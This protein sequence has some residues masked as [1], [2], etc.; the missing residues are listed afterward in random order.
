MAPHISFSSLSLFLIGL[1]GTPLYIP[2]WLRGDSWGHTFKS[3]LMASCLFSLPVYLSL[4]SSL[5]LVS[6][7]L[8]F[9]CLG[10]IILFNAWD[11]DAT[12]AMD[13]MTVLQCNAGVNCL[14]STTG[15]VYLAR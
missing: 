6:Y 14:L 12:D 3:G 4:P 7:F 15:N 13:T 5:L 2:S 8:T 1:I 10:R 11:Y 9:C